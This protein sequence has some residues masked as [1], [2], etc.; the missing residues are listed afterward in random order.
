M[1]AF[2]KRFAFAGTLEDAKICPLKGCR[3]KEPARRPGALAENYM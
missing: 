2:T 1:A 3:G